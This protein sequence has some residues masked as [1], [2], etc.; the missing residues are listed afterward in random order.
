MYTISASACD[1]TPSNGLG[2]CIPIDST[3]FTCDCDV[4]YHGDQ[5]ECKKQQSFLFLTLSLQFINFWYFKVFDLSI[6]FQVF[7]Y[8]TVLFRFY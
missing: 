4:G 5:C 6:H 3:N 1:G 2:T 8:I 7:K